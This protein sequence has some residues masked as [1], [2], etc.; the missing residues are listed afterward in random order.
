MKVLAWNCRG[1]NDSDGP[2]VPFLAWTIRQLSPDIVF[3]M[4]TKACSEVISN[5]AFYINY[6]KFDY[7]ES[8]SNVGGLAI[9][10]KP[11]VR[12]DVKEKSMNFIV[13]KIF[14]VMTGSMNEWDLILV[15]GSPYVEGRF[16]VWN[17]IGSMIASASN[18]VL[19]LGDFN[20]VEFLSQKKGGNEYIPGR[21]YFMFWR[22][23]WNL[24]ELPFRGVP[25]TWCNNRDG[26]DCVYE[27]LDRG[28]ASAEWLQSYAETNIFNLPIFVSDHAPIILDTSP[29]TIR[30]KRTKKIED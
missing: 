26:A 20:Q 1:L 4:E 29:N 28:Y 11:T 9:F 18:R 12:L 25:F 8:T 30:R 6:A 2:T 5:V 7:V 19:L 16:D 14:D 17:D 27:R 3:L 15:Y 21:D 22:N 23:Y 10:W 13:C 24:I